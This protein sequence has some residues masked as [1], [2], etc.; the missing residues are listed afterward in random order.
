M[1]HGP[2]YRLSVG[3]QVISVV[4]AVVDYFFTLVHGTGCAF[5]HTTGNKG[6]TAF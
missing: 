4:L 5:V 2:V 6:T 3:S 1:S